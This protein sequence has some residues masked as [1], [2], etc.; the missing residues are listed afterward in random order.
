MSE[1]ASQIARRIKCTFKGCEKAFPTEKDLVKHKKYTPEHEYCVRCNEDFEDE[2]SHMIH[3]IESNKHIACPICGDDFK[4][5]GGR[6]THFR[7]AH[8][9]EQ[10][11]VCVGC[12][13]TFNRAQGLMAHIESG[14]CIGF[15]EEEYR[16]QRV[17]K[18]ATKTALEGRLG[19][20]SAPYGGGRVATAS[21]AESDDG[22]VQLNILDDSEFPILERGGGRLAINSDVVGVSGTVDDAAS[23]V[24]AVTRSAKQWPTMTDDTQ[25]EKGDLMAFS[26]LGLDDEGLDDEGEDTDNGWGER[27]ESSDAV[28]KEKPQHFVIWDTTQFYNSI[29]GAYVCSCDKA[30]KTSEEI[31]NHLNSGTHAGGVVHCPVCL[32]P[33][34]STAALVAHV[35]SATSRCTIGLSN[36]LGKI[37][38]DISAGVIETSGCHEDGTVKYL[39]APKQEI[40]PE[41]LKKIAW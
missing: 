6:E 16:A 33:F 39:A 32:R 30:F 31:S 17:K 35:E 4:S 21:V 18:R 38:D 23:E 34:K 40:K 27:P 28:E 20:R 9:A 2:E 12:Q 26:E 29:I 24:S 1:P 13:A 41:D 37:I 5:E 36:N 8:R 25:A 11:M 19:G 7:L 15:S 22:G 3:K 14:Q 10:N